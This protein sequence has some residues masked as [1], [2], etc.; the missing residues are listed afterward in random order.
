VVLEGGYALDALQE[1]T[2]AVLDELAGEGL[3]TEIPRAE[4]AE[5]VL[6]AVTRVQKKFWK[7]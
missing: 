4:G 6:D 5:T 7:I 2:A 1:S 3:E